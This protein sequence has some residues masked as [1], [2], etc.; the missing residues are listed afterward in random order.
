MSRKA[1][2]TLETLEEIFDDPQ[3]HAD[4]YHILRDYHD[5]VLN[6]SEQELDEEIQNNPYLRSLR[7]RGVHEVE[8]LP[9]FYERLPEEFLANTSGALV[10]LE[11]D[12]QVCQQLTARHG[13]CVLSTHDTVPA[14]TLTSHYYRQLSHEDVFQAGAHGPSK[15]GWA[16]L[17]S[18]MG[19]LPMNSLVVVDNYLFQNIH[20]GKANLLNLLDAL[21][22]SE[23]DVAFHLLLITTNPRNVLHPESLATLFAELQAGLNRPYPIAFGLLTHREGDKRFHRRAWI[24]NY[25]LGV[26]DR[27]FVC[28]NNEGLVKSHNDIRV[29]GAFRDIGQPYGDIP[30]RSMLL[31]LRSAA[32]LRQH[33]RELGGWMATNLVYGDCD[34]RLLE[35]VS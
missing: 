8:S 16:A 35:L 22:P 13:V 23:L 33:N 15:G 26:S 5:V 31:E 10:I 27:G 12:P 32:A 21:L 19:A 7:K 9:R 24:S 17:L 11:A 30:W 20:E 3:V 28:F 18:P 25:H 34:N 6:L 2:C 29:Q 14:R 1:Y 4:L